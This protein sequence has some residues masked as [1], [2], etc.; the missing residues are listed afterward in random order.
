MLGHKVLI[1]E[2]D[3]ELRGVLGR[4]LREEGF[5]VESVGTGRDLLERGD[6]VAADLLVIDSGL[7]DTAGRDPTQALGARGAKTPVPVLTAPTAAVGRL[8]GLHA[9]VT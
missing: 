7:P 1:A 2:D 3:P 6:A 8:P 5:Q 4:G 9:G